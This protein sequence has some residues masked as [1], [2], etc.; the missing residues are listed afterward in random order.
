MHRHRLEIAAVTIVLA[1]STAGALKAQAPA[2]VRTRSRS[3]TVII[4]NGAHTDTMHLD[5]RHGRMGINVDMRPDPARDSIGARVAGVTTPESPAH[6][7]GVQVGDIIT[8]FNGTPLAVNEARQN[9][10][11]GESRPAMRLIN[12]ASRLSQGDTV[13]LDL[14]R[15]AQSLSVA[16]VAEESDVDEMVDHL[17]EPGTD[18]GGRMR[19]PPGGGSMRMPGMEQMHFMLGGP[20]ADLELV[21]INP[22]LGEYFGTQEGLLVVDVGQDTALGLRAGDV[23]LSI[24]G[25]RPASPPQA[26]RILGTYEPNDSLRFEV[27]RQRHRATVSGKMPARE[28]REW[29]IEPNMFEFD[30][31]KMHGVEPMMHRLELELPNMEMMLPR[32]RHEGP[33][34]VLIRRD[35]ET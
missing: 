16:L 25:R 35:G 34:K 30:M 29:R 2:R 27:M 4:S 26:M 15:G 10:E 31:P 20:V 1:A 24:G 22:G 13:H 9:E 19:L 14:R 3:G 21:K 18:F 7:A 17:R 33:R 23:I 5:E 32:L 28:G 11:E 12:L 8:R 6:R